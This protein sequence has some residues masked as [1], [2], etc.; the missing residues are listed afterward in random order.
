MGCVGDS[1][2]EAEDPVETHVGTAEEEEG[3]EEEGQRPTECFP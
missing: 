3:E 2:E 1:S